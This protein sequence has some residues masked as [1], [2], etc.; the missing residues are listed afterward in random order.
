[1]NKNR[2]MITIACVIGVMMSGFQAS[3][4]EAAPDLWQVSYETRFS[5]EDLEQFTIWD[6]K[7]SQKNEEVAVYDRSQVRPSAAGGVDIVADKHGQT[8][9]SGIIETT[10]ALT[11][12]PGSYIEASI[13]VPAGQ[14]LWPAFW[15]WNYSDHTGV[16]SRSELDIMEIA[17]PNFAEMTASVHTNER[18]GAGVFTRQLNASFAQAFHRFGMWWEEDLVAF[19]VDG[20]E[21]G[22][23]EGADI[24][25]EDMFVVLNLAVGGTW[26]GDPD[27]STPRPATMTV[28]RLTVHTHGPDRPDS[29]PVNPTLGPS[30]T[31]TQPSTQS[32]TE[33]TE[34]ATTV[35]PTA[36]SN[37]AAERALG[38][39]GL[40]NVLQA[41]SLPGQ[42]L[43]HIP[44]EL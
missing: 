21:I 18:L 29:P 42:L 22:R 41:Q 23:Y 15:L 24:P 17:S 28:N 27:A 2:S 8:Y 9:V 35:T 34:V 16:E 31:D 1:M 10:P 14:G 36:S 20:I 39:P 6:D 5:A 33:P 11:V 25:T 32:S 44:H 43:P 38:L 19:Y 40:P 3:Q 7:P 37:E 30:P 4:S 13:R 26:P 12:T